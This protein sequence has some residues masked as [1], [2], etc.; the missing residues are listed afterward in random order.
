MP[1]REACLPAPSAWSLIEA[2]VTLMRRRGGNSF[3]ADPA[4]GTAPRAVPT[5]EDVDA[6]AAEIDA[7]LDLRALARRGPEEANLLPRRLVELGL[8]PDEIARLE[9]VP[10]TSLALH[11]VRQ[12]RR[13]FR[14]S[15]RR[16][17]GIVGAYRRVARLLSQCRNA[18]AAQRDSMV[19]GDEEVGHSTG[20]HAYYFCVPCEFAWPVL[21]VGEAT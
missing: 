21:T 12:H 10:R 13:V 9:P 6:F 3:P 14:G 18:A 15:R 1:K 16:L 11:H 5:G 8:D 19:C 4:S 2:I 7:A 17:P 20:R